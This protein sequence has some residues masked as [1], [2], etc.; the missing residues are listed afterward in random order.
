[1]GNVVRTIFMGGTQAKT[2][3]CWSWRTNYARIN[4]VIGR[5]KTASHM[6][7][8][9]K[10]RSRIYTLNYDF[11][12]RYVCHV[13]Q[14]HGFDVVV[15]YIYKCCMV[16]RF[17]KRTCGYN[18][19]LPHG[20]QAVCGCGST[21]KSF[22]GYEGFTMLLSWI[23]VVTAVSYLTTQKQTYVVMV[24]CMMWWCFAAASAV[25]F[26]REGNNPHR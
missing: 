7:A 12:R 23:R 1:M 21:V 24:L 13:N 19:I 6:Y 14:A 3:G 16:W 18:H 9:Y 20:K 10:Y 4:A 26:H 25:L 5:G 15:V 11:G 8:E 2:F 17:T 22:F